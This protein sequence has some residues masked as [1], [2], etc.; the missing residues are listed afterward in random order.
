M[1]APEKLSFFKEAFGMSWPTRAPGDRTSL[2]PASNVFVEVPMSN[3]EVK[4]LRQ[5]TKNMPKEANLDRLEMTFEQLK[6]QS[7]PIHPDTPGI[8]SVEVLPE[9]WVDVAD[10]PDHSPRVYGLDCEMCV[11][12]NGSEVTRVTLVENE[13][14]ETVLDELVKPYD[15]IID[16]VTTFSGITRE[17]MENVTTRLPDVQKRLLELISTRDVLVGHSLESDLY[18]LK[19]RHPKIIDTS[20]IF[21]HPRGPPYKAGLKMLTSKYLKREI[22]SGTNGHDSAEDAN[23]C[24]DLLAAKL[25]NGMEYGTVKKHNVDLATRLAQADRTVAIVDYGV[26]RWHNEK[27]KAVISCT[28]DDEVVDNAIKCAKTHDFVYTSL[29]ELRVPAGW[30]TTKDGVET[31]S[32][33]DLDQ[34]LEKLNTRISRLY[35]GLPENTALM[36]WSGHGNPT[37]MARLQ[38]KRKAFNDEYKIKKWDEL[39]NS[40]TEQDNQSLVHATKIARSGVSFLTVKG[41]DQPEEDENTPM[42]RAKS[43]D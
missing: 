7:Y 27:A 29:R 39:E 36:I 23:A 16:Y 31:S 3:N 28:S 20:M 37:E 32:E 2:Y 14:R 6:D 13:T 43:E 40:W 26:P 42:K 18:A 35:K 10:T 15:E 12:K 24:L 30:R 33:E 17:M 9:G 21:H 22:Q 5:K 11:T 4:K 34:S 25:G 41:E 8:T 19:L 1:Q 38:K